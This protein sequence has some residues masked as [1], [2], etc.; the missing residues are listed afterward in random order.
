MFGHWPTLVTNGRCVAGVARHVAPR[1]VHCLALLND[2][3]RCRQPSTG[4]T[5]YR[6][7][8]EPGT[9]TM[10]NLDANQDACQ[11]RNLDFEFTTS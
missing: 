10:N 2:G 1:L 5:R 7:L 6:S 3:Q 11:G 8:P 9:I 4:R